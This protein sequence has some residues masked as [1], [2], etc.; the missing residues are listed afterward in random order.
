MLNPRLPEKEFLELQQLALN[1]SLPA[2]VWIA[3]SGS[4]ASEKDSVKLIALSK[5][6]LLHSAK[7]VNEHLQSDSKDIW[8][9]VLPEFHVGGL[10]ISARAYLSQAQVVSGLLNG[11][12]DTRFFLEVLK[13][14]S[15]T[16]A[17][18]VPTQIFDLLQLGE[19]P[20]PSLRAVVVGGGALSDEA[21]HS[22]IQKG[23]PLLPS[24]G[25]T[26]CCSQVATA[27]LDSWKRADRDLYLLGHVQAR[28][29]DE[30]SLSLYSPSLLTGYAQVQNGKQIWSDPKKNGWLTTEDRVE[31]Q[32]RVLKPL[33][34]AADYIKI[35]GEGVELQRLQEILE[36]I[37]R[38][39]FAESLLE[40]AI[41][42]VPEDRRGFELILAYSD[43]LSSQQAEEIFK[44]FNL[45][46]AP[47]ERISKTV[48][49]SEI[50]RTE[51][52]KIAK[53]KLKLRVLAELKGKLQ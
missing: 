21:Y 31:L 2:H 19:K 23:W 20:P 29:E 4:S 11:K 33:G 15:V 52:G 13:S 51:L 47:F 30:G 6:A 5:Q 25:M 41:V 24:Y 38:A 16:L 1:K 36:S 50:P 53:E 35:S 43:K 46:V 3:S 34:R 40:C 27:T 14:K 49:V 39:R 10:G 9:Q 32:G 7:S 42:A 26:E 48:L 12:W 17:A 8:I 45:K 18:L 22:A 28:V 37:L 44:E